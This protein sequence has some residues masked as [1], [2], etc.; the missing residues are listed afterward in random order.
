[1]ASQYVEQN[2][3]GLPKNWIYFC[4]VFQDIQLCNMSR[5]VDT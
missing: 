3:Y 5:L 1:M 4:E 2:V